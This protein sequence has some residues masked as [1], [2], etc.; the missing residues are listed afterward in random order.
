MPPVTL[1]PSAASDIGIILDPYDIL[2][3]VTQSRIPNRMDYMGVSDTTEEYLDGFFAAVLGLSTEILYSRSSTVL[4]DNTFRLGQPVR[5]EYNTT[6]YFSSV[7]TLVPGKEELQALLTSAFRGTQKD[8]YLAVLANLPQTNIFQSTSEVEFVQ[9][10]APASTG[11]ASNG[12]GP[13]ATK[14]A[15]APSAGIAAAAA[16][17]ALI[18]GV[19]GLLMYRRRA[20]V[21]DSVG[22]FLDTDGHMT[23]AGDTYAGHSSLD[24]HSAIHVIESRPYEPSEWSETD[25]PLGARPRD[26]PTSTLELPPSDSDESES[27]D[28][29]IVLPRMT[30]DVSM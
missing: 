4:T 5:V 9:G 15:S 19:T 21:D 23:V 22:K 6:I 1:P 25:V 24:S 20:A 17:G 3:T 30:R 8:D 10:A 14:T 18:L 12:G 28:D 29:S 11:R 26:S 27:D 7:S 2:Y 16:A 13:E